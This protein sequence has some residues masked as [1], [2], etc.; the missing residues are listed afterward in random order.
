M[1]NTRKEISEKSDPSIVET[2]Y[3]YDQDSY[4]RKKRTRKRRVKY[5]KKKKITHKKRQG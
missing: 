5:D 2:L 4:E 3:S 1:D